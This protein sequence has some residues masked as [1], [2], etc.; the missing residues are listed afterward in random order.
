MQSHNQSLWYID[1]ISVVLTLCIASIGLL[2]VYSATHTPE[3]SFSLFFK[4]Q[5]VGLLAGLIIYIIISLSDYR[6]LMQWGYFI[7]FFVIGLLLFTLIKGSIGMG[8]QRWINLSIFKLQPSELAKLFFPAFVSYYFYSHHETRYGSWRDFVPVI[9][10]LFISVFLIRKQPD[11]GTAL[12]ILFSG[13]ILL[14]LAGLSK[15]FFMY[16]FLIVVI[17]A[18]AS[19]HFL[20]PYQRARITVFL[21]GGT[22]QKERYQIEQATIAIGSG[23]L[24]GKGFTHGTQNK[25]QFLPESRTDFIFA[26]LCEEWGFFGAFLVIILYAALFINLL[27]NI[28]MIKEPHIQLLAVGLIIHLILSTIINICMV[29]GLLPIVGIPLPLMSYGL[30]NLFI[31]FA[32]L[33]WLQSIYLHNVA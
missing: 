21:G 16:G 24:L 3:Q 28:S 31:S 12:I 19:W 26:V 11:L 32:S 29:T 18:P 8:A 9:V 13:L 7:Y 4:K 2:F 30:S 10:F 23:G 15:K 17:T 27:L 14:W 22:T 6:S 33:G 25:L 5:A 1:W 20:K